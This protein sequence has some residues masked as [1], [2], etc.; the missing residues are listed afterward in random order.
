[1]R[2]TAPTGSSDHTYVGTSELLSLHRLDGT[3]EENRKTASYDAGL[4]TYDMQA[5]VYRPDTGRFLSADRFESAL[6]DFNL[7]TDHLT[8]DRYAFAGGN[9]V[10]HVEWDG[11]GPFAFCEVLRGIDQILKKKPRRCPRLLTP[12]EQHEVN[13]V[14]TDFLIRVA[15]AEGTSVE[16]VDRRRGARD[17]VKEY[18]RGLA[19]NRKEGVSLEGA[20]LLTSIT[21]GRTKAST[22]LWHTIRDSSRSN[23]G[24]GPKRNTADAAFH[25]AR[26]GEMVGGADHIAKARSQIAAL[27]KALRSTTRG[28]RSAL[29]PRE[30]Q[31]A[32]RTLNQLQDAIRGRPPRYK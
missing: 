12:E 18:A 29:T 1:M 6:G 32:E 5:R 11:R 30:R 20:R 16:K 8:Q 27:E 2:P 4:K 28:G 25:Q 22:K 3:D 13:V 31:I 14:Y 26:T 15:R 21:R 9:P 10:N 23:A 7:Q 19:T 24:V 17:A